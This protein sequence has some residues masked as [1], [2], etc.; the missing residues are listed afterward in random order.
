M[1]KTEKIEKK[2]ENNSNSISKTLQFSVRSKTGVNSYL[3]QGDLVSKNNNL[4]FEGDVRMIHYSADGK[5]LGVLCENSNLIIFDTESG[6]QLKSIQGK[7]TTTFHFSPLNTF[8]LTYERIT[9]EHQEN[10][11]AIWDL[12]TGEKTQKFTQ[13][14]FVY[15]DWPF[16]KWTNDESIACRKATGEIHIYKSNDFSQIFRKLPLNNVAQISLSPQDQNGKF[17]IAAFCPETEKKD[18]LVLFIYIVIQI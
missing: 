4:V 18:L 16:I 7:G 1:E 5:L 14:Q 8:V 12:S 10:N 13:R 6:K 15:D 9:P 2:N 11:L 3:V 17:T